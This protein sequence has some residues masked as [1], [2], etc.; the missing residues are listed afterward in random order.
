MSMSV[1]CRVDGGGECILSVP[2][3]SATG[4]MQ[5]IGIS[6]SAQALQSIFI[7]EMACESIEGLHVCQMK[8]L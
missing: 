2:S 8:C 1:W 5:K 6:Y 3:G 7:C 4:A